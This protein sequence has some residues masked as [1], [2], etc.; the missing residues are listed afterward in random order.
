MDLSNSNVFDNIYN[1]SGLLNEIKEILI[2]ENRF[3]NV[4]LSLTDMLTCN[5]HN[6]KFFH[7][8]IEHKNNPIFQCNFCVCQD[9]VAFL[10]SYYPFRKHQNIVRRINSELPFI[11]NIVDVNSKTLSMPVV[12]TVLNSEDMQELQYIRE[13]DFLKHK[14]DSFFDNYADIIIR[15]IMEINLNVIL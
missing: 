14:I 2:A 10:I 1:R 4:E 15:K 9:K 8:S 3:E 6:S 7:K 11:K 13:D 5:F 12:L